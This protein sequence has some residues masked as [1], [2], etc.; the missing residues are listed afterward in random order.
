EAEDAA[1]FSAWTWFNAGDYPECAKH[2]GALV[3]AAPRASRTA[4][5]LWYVGFCSRLAGRGQ[6]ARSAFE[7]LARS[8]GQWA[9]QALYWRARQ[10]ESAKEAAGFYR[11]SIAAGPQTWYAWLA[12]AR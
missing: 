9:A 4:E 1:F 10:S 5:A 2:F 12:R 8:S 11:R 7:R 6:A 3:E